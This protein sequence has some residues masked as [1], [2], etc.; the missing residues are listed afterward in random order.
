MQVCHI[1]RKCV[2]QVH[3]PKQAEYNLW[4]NSH[5]PYAVNDRQTVARYLR[6]KQVAWV[7]LGNIVGLDETHSA[8]YLF[9]SSP[10][11]MLSS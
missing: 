6:T 1:N 9:L 7:K 4:S 10:V 11:C 2:I 5:H 3:A 8:H